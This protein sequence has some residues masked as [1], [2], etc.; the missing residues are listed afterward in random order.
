MSYLNKNNNTEENSKKIFCRQNIF[1]TIFIILLCLIVYYDK[2]CICSVNKKED[3]T[4]SN[5]IR[6]KLT[7]LIEE[8]SKPIKEKLINS[9]KTGMINGFISGIVGGNVSGC[10]IGSASYGIINP[11][12]TYIE[13]INTKKKD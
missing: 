12:I 4:N 3:M 6:K 5:N 7:E 8:D 11:M 10:I 9:C 13:H 2:Y 1:Y